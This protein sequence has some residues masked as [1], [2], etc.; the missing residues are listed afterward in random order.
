MTKSHGFLD[1]LHIW[2]TIYCFE[3]GNSTDYNIPVDGDEKFRLYFAS[4]E[5]L[6][7]GTE[8]TK[9]FE[10][11]LRMVADG[12]WFLWCPEHT[13]NTFYTQMFWDEN[14]K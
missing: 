3:R 10:A 7:D 1:I 13:L 6:F 12:T 2:T 11:P 4:S 14:E 5:G 9:L 8:N